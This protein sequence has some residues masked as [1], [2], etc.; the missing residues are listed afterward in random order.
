MIC[1]SSATTRYLTASRH[2]AYLVAVPSR[3]ASHIQNRAPGPPATSAV[4]TPTMF[5]VPMV[6]E[7]A[8]QRAPKL[9]TS[10]C[11]PL[12]SFAI[13]CLIAI[14]SL[15]ICSPFKR[16]VRN[17]PTARIRTISGIPQTKSSIAVNKLLIVSNICSS[18][19]F[20]YFNKKV[21]S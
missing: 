4:A 20:V 5:P 16:T 7:S 2:S 17:M 1:P 10:P 19:S 12:F 13:M 9:D 8:V 21:K 14:G 11:S 15:V 6:A 18:L 3:A